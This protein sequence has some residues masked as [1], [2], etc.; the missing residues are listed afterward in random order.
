MHP[1]L[2]R[3]ES[4]HKE[5]TRLLDEVVYPILNKFGEVKI[6]GSYVYQLLNHPDIDLDVVTPDLNIA[7]KDMIPV[8]NIYNFYRFYLAD[9]KPATG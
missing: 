7:T 3:Q 1:L 8:Q 2:Q 9:K 5:A 4:L 6:G